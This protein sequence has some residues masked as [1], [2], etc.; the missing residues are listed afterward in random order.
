[1][2]KVTI[3]AV[4]VLRQM[5]ADEKELYEIEQRKKAVRDEMS[6]IEYGRKQ[7]I[8]QGA[9]QERNIMIARLKSNGFTDEQIKK[10]LE[11]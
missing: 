1:M 7:G 9:E 3:K 8:Q 6:A 5:S 10:L 4:G 11:D 2:S